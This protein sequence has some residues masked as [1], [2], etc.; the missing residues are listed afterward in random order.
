MI[1]KLLF[2]NLTNI[3]T[4]NQIVEALEEAAAS[5]DVQVS[6]QGAE[7]NVVYTSFQS[8]SGCD[9]KAEIE[10]KAIAILKSKNPGLI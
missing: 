8:M 9:Y 4:Y 2:E 5:K 7:W 1:N 10:A 3:N 6:L